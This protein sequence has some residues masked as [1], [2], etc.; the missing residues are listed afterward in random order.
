M[1]SGR[2]SSKFD[3]PGNRSDIETPSRLL[4]GQ[5]HKKEIGGHYRLTKRVLI[6]EKIKRFRLN[7]VD[8]SIL[9]AGN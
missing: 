6:H 3:S 5:R 4:V 9:F 1:N 7:L 2:Q 8:I